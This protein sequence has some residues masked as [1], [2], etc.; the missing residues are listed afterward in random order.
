MPAFTG[1][2]HASIIKPWI[3][4]DWRYTRTRRTDDARDAD[5]HANLT[6]TCFIFFKTKKKKQLLFETNGW[7]FN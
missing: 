7:L 6:K 4:F 1:W 5:L 3:W 2:R